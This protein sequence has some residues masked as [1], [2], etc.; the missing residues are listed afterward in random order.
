MSDL[1]ELRDRFS[2][3]YT[4]AITDVLDRRGYL[5]QT[6]PPSIRPLRCGMRVAGP[7]YPV[8]GRPTPGV[9]YEQSIRLTLAMLGSVPPGHVAVYQTH[10]DVSAHLGELS[11]TSLKSRGCAGAVIDGGCRDVELIRQEGH[12]VFCRHTTPQDMTPRWLLSAH[13]DVTVT[14]GKVRVSP[15]DYVVGDLDGV[16][17]I[18][19]DL[20]DEVLA[21]AEAKVATEGE[22]R[23]A[24]RAGM[25]PL[26]AYEAY[27]TF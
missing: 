13:G 2:A 14:V 19:R 6:L 3:L 27:G 24:V 7:A 4:G 5:R 21:G 8:E 12:P 1:S 20:I 23:R 15:G 10:D 16:V 22:I 17:V 9:D 18:P 11:V 26:E 25:L